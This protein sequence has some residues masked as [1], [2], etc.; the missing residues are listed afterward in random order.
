MKK[1]ARGVDPNGARPGAMPLAPH[2]VVDGAAEAIRFY[3]KAFGASE[4]IRLPGANGRLMHAGVTL[5]GAIVMLVDENPDWNI[6][7]PKTLKGTPVTLHLAVADADAAIAKAAAAGA[8]VI[9]PAS[10]T[11]WGDRYGMV[12]DP[13]GHRW[14]IASPLRAL[15]AAEIQAAA[16][17]AMPEYAKG[18]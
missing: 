2:L 10:D 14:S 18:A 12:E 15:T 1:L 11:F 17:K 8:S 5:N 3:E 13:F 7:S 16:A 9:M 4:F 6:A